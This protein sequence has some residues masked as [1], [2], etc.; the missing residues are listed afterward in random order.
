VS[1][2]QVETVRRFIEAGVRDDLEAMLACLHPEVEM[3]PLR[4]STEGAF[5]GHEGWKRF[6]ADTWSHYEK[7]EPRYELRDLGDSVLVFGAI[8]VRG[9]GSGVEMEV[10][11]AGIFE[12]RDG[13]IVRWQDF[14]SKERALEMAGLPPSAA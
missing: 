11:S 13:L 1:L 9:L 2:E 3:L 8:L 12:F 14:G 10:P 6:R 7:F 4:A 5:R